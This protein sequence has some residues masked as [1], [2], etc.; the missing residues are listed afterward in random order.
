MEAGGLPQ[1]KSFLSSKNIGISCLKKFLPLFQP[2][3][4]MAIFKETR[5]HLKEAVKLLQQAGYDFVDSKMTNLA[6]GEPLEF[7]V[8]EQFGKRKHLYPRHVAVYCQ[9]GKNRY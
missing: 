3:R 5:R 4:G 2:I 7:E 9:S 8:L 6:T 1:A